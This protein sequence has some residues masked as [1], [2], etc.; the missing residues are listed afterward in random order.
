MADTIIT[1]RTIILKDQTDFD[2]ELIFNCGQTFRFDRLPDGRW[3][4]VAKGRV[5]TVAMHNGDVQLDISNMRDVMRDFDEIWRGYFDLDR[6][7]KAIRTEISKDPFTA[8]AAAYGTGIRILRQDAWETLC[9]FILS[10]CNHITRIKGIISRLCALFGAPIPHGNCVYHDFP[11]PE[12]LARLEPEALAPIRAGYRA[13]YI[14][15]AA[16]ALDSGRLDLS[17]IAK[18]PTEELIRALCRLSGVG[19]K[20]ASCAALFGFGRLDAFP[21]DVWIRR[22]LDRYYG[23]M[24]EPGY[25][26][27]YAGVAQQYIFHYIRASQTKAGGK[28]AAAREREGHI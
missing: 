23:G 22:A 26:G 25:F 3:L 5:L 10:Q 15:S 4:G 14:I 21:V 20:V 12:R 16:R 13:D 17:A 1:E 18:L 27:E 6:D 19:N 28:A 11:T 2:P 7:Y 9:S 24:L 8:A